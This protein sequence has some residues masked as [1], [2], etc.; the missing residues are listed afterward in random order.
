M[1]TTRSLKSRHQKLV[2]SFRERLLTLFPDLEPGDVQVTPTGVP[3]DDINLSPK[4]KKM[5]NYSVEAKHYNK[6]AVYKHWEQCLKRSEKVNTEPLLHL[7]ANHKPELVVISA[8]HF[9]KLYELAKLY[10]DLVV[11]QKEMRDN[12]DSIF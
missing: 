10:D 8:D 3:G 1:A 11:M 2:K 6:M 7:K 9:F 12:N 4:A 5:F